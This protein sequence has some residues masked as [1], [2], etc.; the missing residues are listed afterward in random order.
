LMLYSEKDK[1]EYFPLTN[2]M[3]ELKKKISTIKSYRGGDG[4]EDWVGGYKL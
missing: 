4:P 1:D 2:D 3:E